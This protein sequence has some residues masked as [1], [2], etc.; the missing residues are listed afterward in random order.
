MD[1]QVAIVC[2]GRQEILATSAVAMS[3]QRRRPPSVVVLGVGLMCVALRGARVR[4]QSG[5]D[6]FPDS[7]DHQH[8]SWKW[9]VQP[10]R[11]CH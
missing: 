1:R 10:V 7:G 9:T 8:R 2:Y 4:Q 3:R 5:A 11:A 6:H